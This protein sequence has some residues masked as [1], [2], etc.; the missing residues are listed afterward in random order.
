MHASIVGWSLMKRD[1]P[2]RGATNPITSQS[3]YPDPNTPITLR[4]TQL[5]RGDIGGGGALGGD[6]S[7]S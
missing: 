1:R 2:R 6:P 7:A 3:M 4:R 5:L